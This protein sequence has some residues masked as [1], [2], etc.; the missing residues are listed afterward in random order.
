MPQ[1]KKD[2]PDTPLRSDAQRNRE[3]ILAVATEE[4]THCANAP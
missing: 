2:K 1:P 3:R 4:L